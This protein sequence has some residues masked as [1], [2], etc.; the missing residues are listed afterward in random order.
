VD[1]FEASLLPPGAPERRLAELVKAEGRR[2]AACV[3]AGELTREDLVQMVAETGD[4][5]PAVAL[6]YLDGDLI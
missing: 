3:R 2:L 5:E 4:G 1:I 6:M